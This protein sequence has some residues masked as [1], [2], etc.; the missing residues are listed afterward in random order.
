MSFW[1]RFEPGIHSETSK[2][3]RQY[4]LAHPDFL[5]DHSGCDRVARKCRQA[6]TQSAPRMCV[7][8]FCIKE[9]ERGKV[10]FRR[11]SQKTPR[12][13]ACQVTI[14]LLWF[15]FS[16]V[17]STAPGKN[18]DPD[19][20]TCRDQFIAPSFGSSDDN[21]LKQFELSLIKRFH[22]RSML[23][24]K[25]SFPRTQAWPSTSGRSSQIKLGKL[26]IYIPSSNDIE[27]LYTPY[28]MPGSVSTVQS[29]PFIW[30]P[31]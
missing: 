20:N 19:M 2:R 25:S 14:F 13:P 9:G 28:D 22:L 1:P 29:C 31:A 16:S 7:V 30:T 27:A 17:F 15:R 24:S 4:W 11:W 18:L 6:C 3:R 12:C 10:G 8:F 5:M 23:R 21:V 26:P